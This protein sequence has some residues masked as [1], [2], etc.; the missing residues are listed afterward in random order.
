MQRKLAM[1]AGQQHFLELYLCRHSVTFQAQ[2][3]AVG[4]QAR[5]VPGGR[6]FGGLIGF[7]GNAPAVVTVV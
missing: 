3:F 2:P 1:L 7:S 5:A 6:L 4:E